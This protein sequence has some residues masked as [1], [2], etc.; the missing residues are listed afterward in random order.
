MT[1]IYVLRGPL[2]VLILTSGPP[3]AFFVPSPLVMQLISFDGR[4]QLTSFDGMIQ[5]T[6]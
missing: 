2:P 5:L 1:S 3:P 6:A 4:M